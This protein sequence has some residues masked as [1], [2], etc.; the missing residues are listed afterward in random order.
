M[1]ASKRAFTLVELLVVI[2]II[3][4]LI[5]LLLPAVQAAREAARR[6]TCSN[7]LRQLGVACHNYHDVNNSLPIGG[8]SCCWGTWKVPLLMFLE[9]KNLYVKYDQAKFIDGHRYSDSVNRE[10]VAASI[11]AYQCPSDIPRT[12]I[13]T[14]RSHNYAANYGNTTYTQTATYKGVTF[15]GAPF[16]TAGGNTTATVCYKF[17]DILDGLSNTLLFGEVI[18]G[19]GSDLRGFSWWSDAAGFE[20][21][22]AP[23]SPLPDRIYDIGYC[24][25]TDPMNPPCDVSTS[26]WPTMFASRSRH[27]GGVQVSLCDGSVRFISESIEIN[28]WR[29]LSTTRGGETLKEF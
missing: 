3:G 19:S 22:L 17:R 13:S 27:P 1:N 2:A 4:I 25:K 7:N 6:M 15:A 18:Q 12:P 23:N 9:Q 11:D 14:I 28:T 21:Y 16:M 29:A 8:F 26:D 10:V 5:A 24:N 20:T